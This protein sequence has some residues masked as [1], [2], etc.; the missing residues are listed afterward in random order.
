MVNILNLQPIP[1]A[2]PSKSEPTVNYPIY[3][4]KYDYDSRY[5]VDLSFKKGDLMYIISSDE[6]NW[7]F[8]R[9]KDSGEEGYV[10]SNYLA[11]KS[12][13]IFAEK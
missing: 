6:G 3:V 7:W 4:G 2:L 10:P 8:V 5:D 9:L 12:G 11:Y 1:P 13:S